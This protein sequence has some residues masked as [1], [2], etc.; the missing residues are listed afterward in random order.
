MLTLTQLRSSRNVLFWSLHA[1]G[2]LAYALT[3]YFGFLFYKQPTGK[4]GRAS[5][6]ERV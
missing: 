2:W 5:C 3:V 6:R 4:I 1:A